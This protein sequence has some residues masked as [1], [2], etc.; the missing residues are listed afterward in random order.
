M[1]P[2]FYPDMSE[3][4][5]HAQVL[6]DEPVLSYSIAKVLT[7]QTP[8]HAKLAHPKFGNAKRSGSKSMDEGS[9]IHSLILGKGKDI[10]VMPEEYTDFRKKAAQ[11]LSQ[12][13]ESEGKI[14]VLQSAIDSCSE[15]V[16]A[17]NM[18]MKETEFAETFFDIDHCYTEAPMY[19]RDP[20]FGVLMQGM[21]DRFN[22]F[23]PIIWDLKTVT[24]AS[25][26]AIEKKI[27]DMGY[28]IQQAFYRRGINAIM[29]E[30]QNKT[31]FVFLFVETSPPYA[32]NCIEFS[33]MYEALAELDADRAIQI[34]SECIKNDYWPGYMLSEKP[35]DV[36][37]PTWVLKD[38]QLG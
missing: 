37:P 33:G 2:G 30:L 28:H 12:Q 38:K 10:F 19:W 26:K 31:R 4:D 16:T 8:M 5:Y 23:G 9:L 6:T 32:L 20:Y 14:V 1:K 27:F 34:W 13:K 36:M 18:Q 11:E 35:N 15:L 25:T 21:I 17:F 3:S 7:T 29:P 22:S 24:D